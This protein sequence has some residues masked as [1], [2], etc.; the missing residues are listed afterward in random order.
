MSLITNSLDRQSF[1]YIYFFVI[2]MYIPTLQN[3]IDFFLLS[4]YIFVVCVGTQEEIAVP[5]FG[6]NNSSR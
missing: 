5:T 6:S 3:P 4:V 2:V 1:I